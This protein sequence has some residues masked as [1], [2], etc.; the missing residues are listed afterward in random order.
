MDYTSGIGG[1]N[2]EKDE[3]VDSNF[4][5]FAKTEYEVG[6]KK[7]VSQI[8]RPLSTPN[9]TG[10]FSFEI[11]SDPDKFTNAQSL[12]LHGRM[13]IKKRNPQTEVLSNL[14]NEY[15]API[16]NIFDSLWSSIN[17]K[18]N[19]C[20]ITDPSSKWYAYKAYLENHISYSSSCKENVLSYK[21]YYKDT[22]DKFDDVGNS[23]TPTPS[24]NDGFLK[25]KV[26]F[27]G[28]KWVYFA[29]NLHTDITTLRKYIP[30][31][32]KME[33]EFQR[34]INEFLLLS[35]KS[36]DNYAVEIDNMKLKVD[37]IIPSDKVT[38]FYKK[39]IENKISPRLPI[40]RSLL[41]TYTI[42]RG[43]S[44]L[45]HYN[46]ITGNQLPDQVIVAIVDHDAHTGT[47]GKNPFNFKDYDISEASLVV[48]GVH[49]PQE[50]YKLYKSEGDK[51]DMYANFLENTGISTDDREIGITMEDYYGGSFIIAWDRTNDKCNR[52][53][54][55]V[56]DSGA[57][58]INLKSRTPLS[59]SITVI[60]YATYSK[61]LIIDGDRVLTAAF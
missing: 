30:P 29:I 52:F 27:A 11:P 19:G 26:L 45:S 47:I 5:L 36:E 15:V 40:D 38:D 24:T 50:L 51:V 56:S 61:D 20:E 41:K 28:S 53:H 16:N 54:R 21:G 10:P 12:R 13:R 14:T 4:D 49:E 17:I 59:N 32:I 37:R 8:F 43:L 39:N 31:G 3:F 35:D 6:V 7:I 60:V 46:I 1:L 44:D 58:S 48:N 55:H 33:L 34:N 18:L 9:T 57:I 2:V 42:T 25:R 22:Y 23:T